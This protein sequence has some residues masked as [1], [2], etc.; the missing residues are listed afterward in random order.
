MTTIKAP[1]SAG[2]STLAPVDPALAP[3]MRMIDSRVPIWRRVETSDDVQAEAG[4]LANILD[5]TM[6]ILREMDYGAEDGAVTKIW[7]KLMRWF[8][9][10]RVW[11]NT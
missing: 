2:D 7:T 11:P 6:G 8:G 1:A 3:P 10:R 5:A 9:T 4:D